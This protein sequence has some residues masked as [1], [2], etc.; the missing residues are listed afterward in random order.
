MR[1]FILAML[2]VAT[3]GSAG[4][5]WT[6]VGASDASIV[7]ADLATIS[8][9]GNIAKMWH[10]LTFNT[11]QSRPYGLPYWSQKMRQEYDCAGA[12]ERTLEF[13]HYSENMGQGDV[14]HSDAEPGDWKPVLPGTPGAVRLE[15]ACSKR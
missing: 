12:R 11:V 3:S 2:L 13:L 7:Y 4:A 1:K 9:S 15:L 14:T 5:E 10:L 8:K 6:Q